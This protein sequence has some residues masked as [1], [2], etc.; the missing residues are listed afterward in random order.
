M[1]SFWESSYYLWLWSVRCHLMSHLWYLLQ[2]PFQWVSLFFF[3]FWCLIC[4]SYYTVAYEELIKLTTQLWTCKLP[5][6]FFVSLNHSVNLFQHWLVGLGS[7]QLGWKQSRLMRRQWVFGMECVL[8]PCSAESDS[9][10]SGFLKVH[11]SVQGEEAAEC[12]VQSQLRSSTDT[13]NV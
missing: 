8:Y 13:E 10:S 5:R 7:V 3:K 12:L 4:W 1:F 9:G 2:C 6:A 11:C